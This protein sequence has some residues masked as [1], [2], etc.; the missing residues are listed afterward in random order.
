MADER[1]ERFIRLAFHVAGYQDSTRPNYEL[2]D[3]LDR[4]AQRDLVNVSPADWERVKA[5]IARATGT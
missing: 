1:V 3:R 4:E 5:A 2:R